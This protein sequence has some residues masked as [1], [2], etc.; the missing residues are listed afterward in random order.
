MSCFAYGTII[1]IKQL[2]IVKDL[3]DIGDEVFARFVSV[4]GKI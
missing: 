1:F 2:T 3:S 4:N